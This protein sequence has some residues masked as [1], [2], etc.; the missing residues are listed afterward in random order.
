VIRAHLVLAALLLSG[1][2]IE[3]AEPRRPPRSSAVVS[4][5]DS[6]NVRV[7]L[8]NFTAAYERGDLSA[9]ERLFDPIVVVVEAGRVARN[10][11]EYLE[12]SLGPEL[13]AWQERRFEIQSLDLHIASGM[14]WATF[15]YR[16]QALTDR[17]PVSRS[18]LGTA[19]LERRGGLWAI[20]HLHLS[21][22]R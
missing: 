13:I 18:G 14:A 12:R 5:E 16:I 4:A 7:A 11:T 3:R 8:L 21:P 9:L 17:G 1:C 2:T 19:V 15:D 6:A 22:I 20:T 10:W